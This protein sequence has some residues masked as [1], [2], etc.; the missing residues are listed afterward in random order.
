MKIDKHLESSEYRKIWFLRKMSRWIFFLWILFLRKVER[1][2]WIVC[3]LYCFLCFSS[4]DQRRVKTSAIYAIFYERFLASVKIIAWRNEIINRKFD[5][6]S[7]EIDRNLWIDRRRGEWILFTSN[8]GCKR[9]ILDKVLV[10]VRREKKEKQNIPA[11]NPIT[12]M[13]CR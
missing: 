3:I 5:Q 1:H 12:M 4:V 8:L 9:I 7:R 13:G 6:S 10:F 11:F 2:D